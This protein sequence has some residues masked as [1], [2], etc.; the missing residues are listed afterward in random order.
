[1]H[2]H[3]ERQGGP[4][5]PDDWLDYGEIDPLERPEQLLHPCRRCGNTPALRAGPLNA[6]GRATTVAVCS[7][8]KQGPTSDQ[9]FGAVLAWNMRPQLAAPPGYQQL[10]FFGLADLPPAEALAK[11]Q[12]MR[13]HLAARIEAATSR[14]ES[15]R[16]TGA[17]YRRR[18]RAYMGWCVHSL[19]CVEHAMRRA[20]H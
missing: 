1:M 7:C 13:E 18:L 17:S 19:K 2:K 11:L 3:G 9:D 16:S 8:G 4:R 14:S 5:L 15:G 20:P 10:P 12:V 6:Y